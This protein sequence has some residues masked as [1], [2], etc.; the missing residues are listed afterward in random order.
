MHIH[1]WG[2]LQWQVP[3]LSRTYSNRCFLRC[4]SDEGNPAPLP[5][6]IQDLKALL[7]CMISYIHSRGIALKDMVGIGRA[8]VY[9]GEL[10]CRFMAEDCVISL[11]QKAMQFKW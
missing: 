7:W 4:L 10:G 11:F 5:P 8:R 1:V 9:G 3:F 6:G 2:E